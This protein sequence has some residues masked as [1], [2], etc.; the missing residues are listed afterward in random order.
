LVDLSLQASR[1]L[2][3]LIALSQGGIGRHGRGIDFAGTGIE[4]NLVAIRPAGRNPRVIRLGCAMRLRE[5]RHLRGEI[6]RL[7][8]R[9]I[10]VVQVC[11]L[12]NIQLLLRGFQINGG[13]LG[14]VRIRLR[15]LNLGARGLQGG[16]R[17][18][19]GGAGRDAQRRANSYQYS[20]SCVHV[21]SLLGGGRAAQGFLTQGLHARVEFRRRLVRTLLLR[22]GFGELSVR[23]RLLRQQGG[24]LKIPIGIGLFG[25]GQFVASAGKLHGRKLRRSGTFR[26]LHR[27]L[28]DGDLLVGKRVRGGACRQ[29]GGARRERGEALHQGRRCRTHSSTWSL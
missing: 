6:C 20:Y 4:L 14:D 1:L 2:R 29:N 19:H 22:R 10:V 23:V 8:D 17:L 5:P 25:A 13:I 28:R 24:G 11:V 21:V 7:G 26:A 16:I 12:R 9:G 27:R 18:G 3:G 15:R